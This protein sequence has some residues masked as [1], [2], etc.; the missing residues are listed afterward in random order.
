MRSCLIRKQNN[1][2]PSIEPGSRGTSPG[3]ALGPSGHPGCRC[4]QG[5]ASGVHG[6]QIPGA[7]P[8]G[9]RVR[10][11]GSGVPPTLLT[12]SRL[13]PVPHRSGSEAGWHPA[14]TVPAHTTPL[15]CDTSHQHPSQ[16][17][18]ESPEGAECQGTTQNRDRKWCITA[19]L[20]WVSK[21]RHQE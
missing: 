5:A 11:S 15:G 1:S 19:I 3:A 16:S 14:G 21:L 4:P 9:G 7:R 10:E 20:T 2:S 17:A 6:C 12:S 13:F 8:E 18:V